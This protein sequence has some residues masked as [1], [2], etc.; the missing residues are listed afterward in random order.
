MNIDTSAL[1]KIPFVNVKSGKNWIKQGTLPLAGEVA[2]KVGIEVA[3]AQGL[4]AI[5]VKKPDQQELE[6]P[7]DMSVKDA[8]L[9]QKA[10]AEFRTLWSAHLK[11]AADDKAAAEAEKAKKEA[12]KAAA[13]EAAAAQMQRN[14]LAAGKGF[15]IAA[16]TGETLIANVVKSI[17]TAVGKNFVVSAQGLTVKEGAKISEEDAAVLVSTMANASENS[18]KVNATTLWALGDAVNFVEDNFANGQDIITAVASLN[19]QSKHTIVQ[20]G[21]VAKA[22][23]A[24]K[25]IPEY[26]FTHHQEILNYSKHIK[27]AQLEKLIEKAREDA[28]IE[29]EGTTASGE[30]VQQTKP[31]SAKKL[32]GML[33]EASKGTGT[34]NVGKKTPKTETPSNVVPMNP[35]TG[36]KSAPP[37]AIA[38]A[39]IYITTSGQVF[40]SSILSEA[41]C[42]SDEFAICIDLAAMKLLEADA[43]E[44]ET[45]AQLGDEWLPVKEEEAKAPEPAK[46]PV[47]ARKAA[48]KAAVKKEEA[49]PADVPSNEIPD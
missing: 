49:A 12:E 36:A 5:V 2:K 35:T 32:R 43:S 30:E 15:A 39:F 31:I 10:F 34:S 22:F 25:R 29:V 47:L 37:V 38:T 3:L 40:K 27:P 48:K 23:P 42:A 8:K 14:T 24:E 11:K 7:E 44:G 21:R 45:V 28:V 4:L 1:K 26:S 9:V 33:Q 20:A 13:K 17:Q 41:A 46:A 18:G 19:G 16:Q 6:I